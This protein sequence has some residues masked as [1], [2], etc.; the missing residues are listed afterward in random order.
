[1]IFR[2]K[3]RPHERDHDV[4]F[5][6][7][8]KDIEQVAFWDVDGAKGIFSHESQ[9]GDRVSGLLHLGGE[10]PECHVRRGLLELRRITGEDHHPT[11]GACVCQSLLGERLSDFLM[12]RPTR[13][14]SDVNP[15]EGPRRN[16]DTDGTG[17]DGEGL[18]AA[19]IA[20]GSWV[21]CQRT[22]R[23]LENTT[24][25]RPLARA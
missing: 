19:M 14:R 22:P 25:V 1:M 4:A 9:V 10:T 20:H 21:G 7:F 2:Q 18:D 12:Q 17:A 13:S 16:T 8:S 5:A 6:G 11:A 23:G 24:L 15:T 3:H